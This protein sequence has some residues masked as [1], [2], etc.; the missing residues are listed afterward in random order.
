MFYTRT[1]QRQGS[2]EDQVRRRANGAPSL[3]LTVLGEFVLPAGLPVWTAALVRALAEVGVEEKS[4][5]Q[6]LARTADEGILAPDRA[7]RRVRWSLTESGQ[8][9]LTEGA[10]RIYGFRAGMPAWDGQWLILSVTVPERERQVRHRL[11]T[12]LTWAGL[13]TPTPGLWIGPDITKQAEVADVIAGLG[14]CDSAFSYVGRSGGI[15]DVRRLVR[16]AWDLEEVARRYRG[17]LDRFGTPRNGGFPGQVR[18]VQEWRHFPF[19]DPSLPYE[20]LPERWPGTR[21]ADLFHRRRAAWHD[22]AQAH[23]SALAREDPV[24]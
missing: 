5:R 2:V 17:F 20:L 1:T 23:W 12:R 22:A 4:A 11:R 7:G 14:L 24:R 19:L 3:L 15:G 21:A 16:Q 6:A 8:R 13:G 18:L 9:L 10:A